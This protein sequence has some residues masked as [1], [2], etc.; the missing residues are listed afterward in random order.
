MT[1]LEAQYDKN[2]GERDYYSIV[3]E[4]LSHTFII[5]VCRMNLMKF[6]CQIFLSIDSTTQRKKCATST[7]NCVKQQS[8]TR[9]S[10]FYN[11]SLD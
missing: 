5:L 9:F 2:V 10:S 1:I 6:P 4:L 8:I 11:L 7:D 3:Y